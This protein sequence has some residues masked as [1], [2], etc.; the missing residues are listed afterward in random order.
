MLLGDKI[1]IIIIFFC[2]KNMP[3]VIPRLIKKIKNHFGVS[4][5]YVLRLLWIFF[6]RYALLTYHTYCHFKDF[7]IQIL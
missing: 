2:W 7:I 6:N 5:F 4:S 3:Y 1:E